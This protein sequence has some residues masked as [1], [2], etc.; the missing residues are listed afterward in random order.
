M[1]NINPAALV[2]IAFCTLSGGIF[3]SYLFGA[4]IGTGMVVLV[5][6]SGK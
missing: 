4:T 1:K 6:V 3:G 5:T 2:F